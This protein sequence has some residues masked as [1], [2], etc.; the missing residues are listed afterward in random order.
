MARV[1]YLDQD[2]IDHRQIGSDRHAV[3]EVSRVFEAPLLV[4]DVFLVER[5][6]DALRH[7]TLDLA[8]DI[9]GMDRAADILHGGVAQD[10]D[11]AG[12]AIDLDVANMGCPAG[13]R[14]L[15]VDRHLG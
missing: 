14:A 15:R 1:R 12:F 5:P 9:G 3:V 11:V 6:A 2:R 8:L 4:V 10:L 13:A 7:A